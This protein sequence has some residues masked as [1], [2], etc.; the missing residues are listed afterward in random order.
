MRISLV[1]T[2][3]YEGQRVPATQLPLSFFFFF[4]FFFS[5]SLEMSLFPSIF[6]PL[7]FFFLYMESISYVFPFRMV[8]FLPCDHGL[9]FLHKLICEDPIKNQSIKW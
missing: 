6:V 5:L 3:R 8:I 4:S 2:E 9:D 7:P 1:V